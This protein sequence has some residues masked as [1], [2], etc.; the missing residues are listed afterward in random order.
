MDKLLKR[1][2]K[3]NN[4]ILDFCFYRQEEKNIRKIHRTL[5]RN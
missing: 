2:M 5:E 4:L 3:V 1:V